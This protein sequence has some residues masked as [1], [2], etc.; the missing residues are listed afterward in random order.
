MAT[1]TPQ[2]SAAGLVTYAA[3]SAGGDVVAF[4]NATNR[5][6]VLVRNA[7]GASVNVTAA[8]TQAC[9][10]GTL[11]NYVVACPVGDTEFL[12]PS[13]CVD[14]TPATRGNVTLTYSASTSVSVGAVGA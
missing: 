8:A 4:G 7:S 5:P 2:T 12:V 9:S 11:H 1:I 14:A 6:L 3:A 13:F 10:Q